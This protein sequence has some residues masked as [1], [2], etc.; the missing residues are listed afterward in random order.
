[1]NDDLE[2]QWKELAVAYFKVSSL[3]G[4]RKLAITNSQVNVSRIEIKSP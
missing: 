1:M 4:V 2:S 3:Q